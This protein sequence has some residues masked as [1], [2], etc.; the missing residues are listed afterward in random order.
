MIEAI[1]EF[2]Q[3][4]L[5]AINNGLKSAFLDMVCPFMRYKSNWYPLYIVLVFVSFKQ[6]GKR[7]WWVLGAAIALVLVSD[8]L[9]ANLIKNTVQRIRPC[10]TPGLKGLLHTIVGCSAIDN[11]SFVSAHA[12]NHFA[13]AVFFGQLL[14]TKFPWMIWAGLVWAAGI[15]FSQ[16]YVGLHFP[17]DV[18]C[19]GILGSTLG[20]IAAKF[21]NQKAITN[22]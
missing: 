18:I 9:S 4:L 21:I 7:G 1:K 20:W 10:N 19:G 14:K 15:A 11:Y 3:Q 13:I 5:L 8:Q 12:T 6:W 17:L 16:V 2:D 22:A